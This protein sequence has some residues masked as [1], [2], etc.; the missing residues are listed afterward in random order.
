MVTEVQ[1]FLSYIQVYDDVIIGKMKIDLMLTYMVTLGSLSELLLHSLRSLGVTHLSCF[2][3]K[4]LSPSFYQ[5]GTLASFTKFCDTSL[6][7]DFVWLLS[8]LNH[9]ESWVQIPALEETCMEYLASS[10]NKT[11]LI[12]F[13][14]TK[15][16]A[17][18]RDMAVLALEKYKRDAWP[19][20][21]RSVYVQ[22]SS[23][24][25]DNI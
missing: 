12:M 25:D 7:D 15:L 13:A 23:V 4:T 21:Y 20:V 2:E 16:M 11:D 3:G 17:G 8:Q 22:T 14:M 18:G 9:F 6:S 5:P 1:L 19:D 10:D 24:V